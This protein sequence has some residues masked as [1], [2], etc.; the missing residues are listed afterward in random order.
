MIAITLVT[1][2][3][4]GLGEAGGEPKAGIDLAQE[5]RAAI[6]GE[7]TAGEI[8]HDLAAAEVGKEQRLSRTD[9]RARCGSA[10]SHNGRWCQAI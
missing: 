10:G 9:C 4:E 5:Q 6:T 7:V 1:L 3:G 2:V 8:G